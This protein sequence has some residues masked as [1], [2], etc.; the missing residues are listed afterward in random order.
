MINGI[1][2]LPDVA[3]EDKA[4]LCVVFARLTQHMSQN[5]HS[6]VISFADATGKRIVNIGR[7]KYWVQDFKHRVMKHPI[8]DSGLVNVTKLWIVN[9]KAGIT[10]V[11]VGFVAKI[12]M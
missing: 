11:L 4:C 2:K 1:K 5:L 12:P 6:F 7:F 3:L 10:A 9:I 8:P